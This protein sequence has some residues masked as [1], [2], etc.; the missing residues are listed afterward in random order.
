MK[1]FVGFLFLFLA[2]S[3][4]GQD[5]CVRVRNTSAKE[6][7][8]HYPFNKATQI[9]IVSFDGTVYIGIKGSISVISPR[10]ELI[11]SPEDTVFKSVLPKENITL[12]KMQ[13]DSLT[14]I[15]YNYGFSRPQRGLKT[16]DCYEPRNAVVFLDSNGRAFDFLEVCFECNKTQSYSHK[17]GI[18]GLCDGKLEMMQALF[19]H[20]GMK[21]GTLRRID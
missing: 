14:D 18:G 6:R 2:V 13:I 16:V 15:L 12:N 1:F 19:L 9:Q 20:A 3:V 4:Y 8:K 11:S 7:M 21:H 17:I 10:P 5:N